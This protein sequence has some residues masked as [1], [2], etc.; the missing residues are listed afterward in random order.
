MGEL[1]RKLALAA[2]LA[3]MAVPAVAQTAVAPA[4]QAPAYGS[5]ARSRAKIHTELGSMYFQAGNM[6]VAL[7]E[8]KVAIAADSGYAPAYTVLGLVHAYLKENDEAERVFRRAMSLA[9]NDPEIS[10]NYGW[11]LCQSGR[12]RQSIAHFLNAV[13][14]PLYTTPDRAY[15]NAGTCAL[16]AGDYEGAASYLQT[17]IRLG[18]EG[19]FLARVQ[20]ATLTYRKG[21]LEEARRLITDILKVS[22]PPGPD[23]L[24]LALR[25][26]RKLGNRNAESSLAAQLRSRYPESAEY[27]DFL[28]GNF[29]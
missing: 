5:D 17:A 25:V 27:Q 10:N 12:E 6:A 13:K 29:E 15:A 19:G 1:K 3:A 20:L 28:K 24:R 9:P 18:G 23:A 11:F 2:L 21:N 7:E 14:N 22:D 4:S 26:E 8:L 16:K